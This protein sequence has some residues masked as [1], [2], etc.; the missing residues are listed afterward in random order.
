M[1]DII[2]LT[3]FCIPAK[4]NLILENYFFHVAGS[5]KGITLLR[6]LYQ[7]LLNDI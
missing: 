1:Y 5:K 4:K 3:Y 7:H 2:K 6:P